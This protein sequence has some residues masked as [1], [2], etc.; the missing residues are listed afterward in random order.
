MITQIKFS[1]PECTY[2]RDPQET[3][4]GIQL[5]Q[6]SIELIDEIGFDAF[7]F[8]KLALSM[9]STEASIYRYF[10]NKHQLLL[11][12]YAWYWSWMNYRLQQETYNISSASEKLEMAIQLLI[13]KLEDDPQTP[14]I[15][16]EKLKRIIEQEGIK[17]ILTKNVDAVNNG[18]AFED[19]K[20][21][22]EKLAGWILELNPSFPYPNMLVSTIIEGAHLQHYFSDHLPRLTNKNA[23]NDNVKAFFS[24]LIHSFIANH[25][26]NTNG[27]SH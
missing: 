5:I 15:N 1:V 25:N 3:K 24:Q 2:L 8:K 6:S 12:L 19:Y 16:E 10:E 27:N 18:G 13:S 14:F 7:N 22:V 26:N 21:L 11:F 23:S 4:L 9:E 20:Q 17:S